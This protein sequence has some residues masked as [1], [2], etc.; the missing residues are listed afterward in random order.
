MRG[1]LGRS[2]VEQC[3]EVRAPRARGAG[4]GRAAD[5]PG[6]RVTAPQLPGMPEVWV[7]VPLVC[8][9]S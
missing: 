6:R 8:S 9:A 7:W 1:T 5:V 2:P 3:R 4:K